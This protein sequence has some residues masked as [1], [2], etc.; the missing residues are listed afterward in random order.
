MFQELGDSQRQL[1]LEIVQTYVECDS[2]TKAKRDWHGCS[3]PYRRVFIQHSN[4]PGMEKL[5]C[6][7]NLVL[8]LCV[9]L[10]WRSRLREQLVLFPHPVMA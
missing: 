1:F 9:G 5:Q 10:L 6:V 2:V 4:N 3:K 7:C 8:Y